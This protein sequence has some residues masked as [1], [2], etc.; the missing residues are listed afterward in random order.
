MNALDKKPW[1]IKIDVFSDEI[2]KYSCNAKSDSLLKEFKLSIL[3]RTGFYSIN[4]LF[5]YSNRDYTNFDNFKLRDIFFLNKE[6]QINLK[7]IDTYKKGI[8]K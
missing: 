3:K 1:D 6:V 2:F 4:Y 8:I 7:S 5:Y